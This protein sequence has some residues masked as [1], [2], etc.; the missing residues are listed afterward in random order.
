MTMARKK[1]P[2][3]WVLMMRQCEKDGFGVHYGHW[4]ASKEPVVIVKKDETPKDWPLCEYEPCSKRFKP[5]KGKR[6]C[7]DLC[8]RKAYYETG[9]PAQQMKEYRDMRRAAANG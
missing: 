1:K 3:K 7:C 2:D 9:K 6:F 8:R 4:I 5:S